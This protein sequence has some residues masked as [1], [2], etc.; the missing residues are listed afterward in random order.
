MKYIALVVIAV[1][2][3]SLGKAF[4][5]FSSEEIGYTSHVE[6]DSSRGEVLGSRIDSQGQMSL[7]YEN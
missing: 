3:I 4:A 7:V 2:T 5:V 6:V 1:T